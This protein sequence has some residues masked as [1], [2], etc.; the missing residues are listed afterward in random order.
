[1][2]FKRNDGNVESTVLAQS[3]DGSRLLIKSVYP[4]AEYPN[5]LFIDKE[6]FAK[7][8]SKAIETAHACAFV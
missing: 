5:I 8:Y 2:Q 1:M 6:Y 4:G 3:E 7:R